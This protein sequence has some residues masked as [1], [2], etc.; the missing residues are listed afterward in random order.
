M[1]LRELLPVDFGNLFFPLLHV[2]EVRHATH[3]Y[4]CEH[5][6]VD[7]YVLCVFDVGFQ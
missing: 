1:Q 5:F 2:V 3:F 6:F 7:Y 4:V